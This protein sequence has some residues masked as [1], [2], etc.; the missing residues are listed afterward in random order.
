MDAVNTTQYF[1]DIDRDFEAFQKYPL[2]D[3]TMKSIRLF[4]DYKRHY[5]INPNSDE[6]FLMKHYFQEAHSDLKA[7]CSNGRIS[8]A[9]LYELTEILKR[10][11]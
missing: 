1:E 2:T 7:E 8:S 5:F 6:A 4:Y 11:L 3:E 9:T 10:G